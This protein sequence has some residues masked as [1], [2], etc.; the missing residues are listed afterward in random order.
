M[1]P[2]NGKVTLALINQKL[3]TLAGVVTKI[4]NTVNGVED[5]PGLKGRLVLIED[6]VKSTKWYFRTVWAA[7]A[8]SGIGFYFKG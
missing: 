5:Q 2:T 1:A 6:Y 3:D 8:A 4:D 7:I